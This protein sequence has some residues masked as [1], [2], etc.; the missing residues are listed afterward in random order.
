M[1]KKWLSLAVLATLSGMPALA[2]A[3]EAAAP[4]AAAE[5]ASPHTVSYNLGLYS[6]Y[7]FRG[8]T[9]TGEELALQGGVDYSHASGFYAGAWASNVSWLEDSGNFNESSLELDLYGG[10][11][12]TFGKSDFGYDIGAL[13]YYYPGD[14]TAAGRAATGFDDPETL[15]LY[16]AL[17][18]KWIQ[19]KVSWVVTDDAW[20]TADGQGTYYAELNANVPIGETGITANLHV[21][22]QEFDGNSP[23]VDNDDLYSYTDWKIG[24]T[25]SFSNGVNVG[26]FYSDTNTKDAGWT[27]AGENI[28]DSQFTIFVQKLF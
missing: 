27:Y 17:T 12:G 18:W 4:A 22:R 9:Q 6:Q 15:E 1:Q 25:K 3:E 23:G 24:A 28:G 2:G 19:A 14:K 5:P 21:G 7:I 11:R 16:G 8:L 13:L 26:A 20:G 10:Y